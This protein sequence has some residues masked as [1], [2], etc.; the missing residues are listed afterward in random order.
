[1][2]APTKLIALFVL[3]A[4]CTIPITYGM[5][6]DDPLIVVNSEKVDKEYAELLM[7][8]YYSKR[9]LEINSDNEIVVTE[10]ICSR[11]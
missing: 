1:M 4:L 8:K 10:N 6:V 7:D 9:T 3:A 11:T 2:S 5:V